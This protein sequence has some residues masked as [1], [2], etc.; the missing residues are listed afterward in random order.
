VK[1]NLKEKIN[2]INLTALIITIS[3]ILISVGVIKGKIYTIE[4]TIETFVPEKEMYLC[5]K[6]IEEKINLFVNVNDIDHKYIKVELEKM[7]S[8]IDKIGYNPKEDLIA[9]EKNKNESNKY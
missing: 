1:Q 4:N 9:K 3:T 7:N 8:K 5:L 6:N 2:L